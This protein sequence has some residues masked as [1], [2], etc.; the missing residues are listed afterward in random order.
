MFPSGRRSL[1]LTLSAETRRGR[2]MKVAA[3]SAWPLSGHR[4]MFFRES[5]SRLV[6]VVESTY[7]SSRLLMVCATFVLRSMML[8][9]C[10]D[11]KQF[12]ESWVGLCRRHARGG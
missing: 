12:V 4:R 9:V 6:I 10:V 8:T 11:G 7:C 2:S 5:M 1:P 3:L